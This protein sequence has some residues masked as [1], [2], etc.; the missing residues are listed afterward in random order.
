MLA[1]G[2]HTITVTATDAAGNAGTDSSG[3][4]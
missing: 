1:D 4:D 3:D 2:P